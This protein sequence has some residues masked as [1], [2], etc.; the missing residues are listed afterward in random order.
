MRGV[1]GDRGIGGAASKGTARKAGTLQK[2][3]TTGVMPS[4]PRHHGRRSSAAADRE[5]RPYR[6]PKQQGDERHEY[7]AEVLADRQEL[8][9]IEFLGRKPDSGG[10]RSI[11]HVP[12]E[13]A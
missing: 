1:G 6:H 8:Q 2:A 10:D 9:A 13:V 3:T 11:E 4:P 5:S 12:G 7:Q